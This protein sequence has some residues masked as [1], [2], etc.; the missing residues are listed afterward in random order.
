MNQMEHSIWHLMMT[1]RYGDQVSLMM[2]C[3]MSREVLCEWV[4][5]RL[6]K[7]KHLLTHLLL[8]GNLAKLLYFIAL[9]DKSKVDIEC[10]PH[11]LEGLQEETFLELSLGEGLHEGLLFEEECKQGDKQCTFFRLLN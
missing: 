5:P 4:V 9:F 7:D 6:A 10:D 2:T 1:A 3:L 11:I 8:I